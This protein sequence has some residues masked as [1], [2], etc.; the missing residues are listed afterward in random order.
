MRGHRRIRYNQD[1]KG[2]GIERGRKQKNVK[3]M[4]KIG[5]YVVILL[6]VVLSITAFLAIPRLLTQ[7]AEEQYIVVTMD[8][9]EIHR[10]PMEDRGAPYFID[11][12]F[13]YG[14]K[15]YTG[16]LEVDDGAVRLHRLPEEIVPLSIHADMGWIRE[17]YQMIVSLP[18]RM[19][20]SLEA[21]EDAEDHGDIDVFAF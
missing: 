1:A 4:M 19:Y 11:F 2:I 14:G 15:T 21:Q 16:R 9:E 3:N 10:F 20:I 12:P 13:E 5:D 7:E 17:S 18:V 6:V 8:G